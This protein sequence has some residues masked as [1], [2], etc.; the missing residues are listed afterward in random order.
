MKIKFIAPYAG[1]SSSGIFGADGKEIP[2]GTEVEVEK[3]PIDLR[4]RYEV[5]SGGNDEGKTAVN[6]PVDGGP[7]NKAAVT[8]DGENPKPGAENA[9][10]SQTDNGTAGGSSIPV[11]EARDKGEGWWGIYD[12]D[13]N[14]VGKSIRKD[15]A[16]K[17]N[18]L[19]DE[20]KAEFVKQ[21]T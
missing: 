18:A 21:D 15:E 17:F 5:V 4:G 1:A 8:T 3:E 2:L 7:L 11:Y 16:A 12:A 14:Q 19:S 10:L 20:V 13:G 9:P 6:N